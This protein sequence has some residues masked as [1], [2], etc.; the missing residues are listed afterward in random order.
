[1]TD[2]PHYVPKFTSQILLLQFFCLQFLEGRE[3]LEIFGPGGLLSH[4]RAHAALFNVSGHQ[5]HELR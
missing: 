3:M 5:A 1:M 4:Y 2:H